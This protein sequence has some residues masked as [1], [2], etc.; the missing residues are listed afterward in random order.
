MPVTPSREW[1]DAQ[2]ATRKFSRAFASGFAIVAAK[3][4]SEVTLAV[5]AD[6]VKR[7]DSAP[8]LNALPEDLWFTP[9]SLAQQ[10]IEKQVPSEQLARILQML[11]IDPT[12]ALG[13]SETFQI[14]LAEVALDQG[15][16]TAGGLGIDFDIS[17]PY[18]ERWLKAHSG[19][20]VALISEQTRESI[21]RVISEAYLR[22][23]SP[24]KTA[25]QLKTMV[26]LLPR[27]T[28]WVRNHQDR[29]IA[30]GL[31]S[32]QVRRSTDGFVKRVLRE[33]GER[34][35]RTEVIRANETGRLHAW[36]VARDD[37][38][39]D[40]GASKRWQS[41]V[42]EP[43][44]KICRDLH[45]Q[46]VPIDEPFQ[47]NVLR[48]AVPAPPAHPHCRCSTSLKQVGEE[49]PAGFGEGRPV[50]AFGDVESF[51]PAF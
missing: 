49:E 39:I 7:G 41:G 33:R 40:A 20:L 46:V 4:Q 10:R 5:I 32:D 45:G 42:V 24:I 21:R 27:E 44:C 31:S 47:S 8:V 18:T 43:T 22:G 19:E 6:A 28:T 37:G 48:K 13:L 9:R 11:G 26:G 15:F 12:A 1:R 25:Q 2:A 30:Q 38:L 50:A 29:L 3:L 17:N 35:A 16:K 23:E 36:K 51:G 34:I 14:A